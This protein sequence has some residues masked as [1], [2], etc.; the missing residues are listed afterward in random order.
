MKKVTRFYGGPN[1]EPAPGFKGQYASP[2]AKGCPFCGEAPILVPWHGG[3]PRKR[4]VMC[5]STVCGVSPMVTGQTEARALAAWN[6]RD[7]RT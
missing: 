1:P 3:G 6:T 2:K 4:A 5:W 7:G